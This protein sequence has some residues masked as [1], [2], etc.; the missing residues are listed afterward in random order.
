MIDEYWTWIFFGYHSDE[1]KP[2]SRKP[3]VAGCDECC[4]YRV[5]RN[6][7]YRDF[8]RSCAGKKRPPASEEHRRNISKAAIGRKRAPFSKEHLRRIGEASKGR[9]PSDEA[10]Q[11]MSESH[12][13][14][15][16]HFF[17]EHHTEKAKLKIS[18]HSKNRVIT[19]ECRNKMSVDRAG[20]RN[21]FFGK[22]HTEE[23]C[24]KMSATKQCIPYEE[25]E[26]FATNDWRDWGK[27]VYLNDPF[28][29]CHRHHLTKTI[30]ACI[31][32]ELHRHIPHT[33]KTGRNMGEINLLALQFINGEL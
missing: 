14:K 22:R 7:S 16:N 31:P 32:I 23:A 18:K 29:H 2:C 24:R 10:R 30:V 26:S 15:K 1:L 28:P 33:I 27:A 12:T 6:D 3:V 9:Y 19:E 20:E 11:K 25:W 13:G 21:H 17:G 5:L 4:Q 8:C